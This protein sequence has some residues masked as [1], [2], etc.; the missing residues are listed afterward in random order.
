[1]LSLLGIDPGFAAFGLAV[2]QEDAAGKLHF[3]RVSV[4]HTQPDK[5]A[6]KNRRKTEDNAD[7]LQLLAS[8]LVPAVDTFRP[9]AICIEA[10]ALPFGKVQSSV[11]SALGRVRGMIDMLSFIHKLPVIEAHPI[12]IKKLMTGRA[13][14]TKDDVREALTALYPELIPIFD[15]MNKGDLEHAADACAA[16][17]ISR[18]TNELRLVRQGFTAAAARDGQLG[19]LE[20]AGGAPW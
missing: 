1:M 20:A 18:D 15:D 17:H 8:E 16:I 10:I 7:R 4:L 9:V 13:N 19:K 6:K 3:E 2:A 14:A 5:A 11:V 12:R